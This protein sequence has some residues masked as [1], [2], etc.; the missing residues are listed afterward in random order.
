MMRCAIFFGLM[1]LAQVVASF[2]GMTV[3]SVV[4]Q[5]GTWFFGISGAVMVGMDVV[6]FINVFSRD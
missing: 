2:N 1:M 4:G 3:E 5:S 6:D